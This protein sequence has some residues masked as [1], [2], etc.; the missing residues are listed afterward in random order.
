MAEDIAAIAQ[1]ALTTVRSPAELG[2]RSENVEADLRTTGAAIEA[3]HAEAASVGG[4]PGQFRR[5]VPLMELDVDG[6]GARL[7]DA[8]LRRARTL[9]GGVAKGVEDDA[10]NVS[11]A[12]R[13]AVLWLEQRPKTIDELVVAQKNLEST[14]A[15]DVVELRFALTQIWKKIAFL[16][17]YDGIT[18][19]VLDAYVE[20][21]RAT[22]EVEEQVDKSTALLKAERDFLKSELAKR[23]DDIKQRLAK[24]GAK[25]ASFKDKSNAKLI[26]EYVD[27]LVSNRDD[28]TEA[29]AQVAKFNEDETKL[30][31]SKTT[32]FPSVATISAELEPYEQLWNTALKFHTSYSSWVKGPLR[33]LD[34]ESVATEH[35]AM[36][37]TFADLASRLKTL[38]AHEP[39]KFVNS[40][41][42]QL[43]RFAPNVP[44]VRTLSSPHLK[45]R[46]WD[47][48]SAIVGFHIN[49]ENI[50][51]LANFLVR[52][53][54]R[55]FS[56]PSVVVAVVTRAFF[57]RNSA[58]AAPPTRPSASRTSP[59]EPPPKPTLL[60]AGRHSSSVLLSFRRFI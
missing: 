55:C 54:L 15:V 8:A 33:S 6:L 17:D 20:G 28:L 46:H 27:Q 47:D 12:S 2:I 30:S 51:N 43:E 56:S 41:R 18:R 35:A 58:K 13:V 36:I 45:P 25:V 32:D 3:L 26:R 38:K 10:R 23:R 14:R 59:T 21:H 11:N 40:I 19:Q 57:F 24:I 31:L 52:P 9:L 39:S 53:L 49:A 42:A 37:A 44:V 50:T 7:V 60:A 22:K 5:R 16:V 1:Q 4:L 34:G 48:I 29:T